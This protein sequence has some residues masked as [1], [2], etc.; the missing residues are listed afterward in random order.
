MIYCGLLERQIAK[1]VGHVVDVSSFFHYFSFDVMGELSFGRS[2]DMLRS[3]ERH[4]AI[5]LMKDGMTLLGLFT[6]TPW[7][8][9]IGFS[10]PGVA[11]GWKKMFVWS[12]EQMRQRIARR[13]ERTDIT[14]WLI[15]ASKRNN[16]LEVDR[17][18]LNGDAFGIIIAGSD[19]TASTL[20]LVFYHLAREPQHFRKIRDELDALGANM[21]ARNLQTLP[22]LNAF[23]NES[24]RLH[25]PVP[26]AGLRET[27]PEGLMIGDQYIPGNTVIGLPMYSLH[28]RKWNLDVKIVDHCDNTGAS[29]RLQLI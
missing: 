4:F 6:P 10:L 26:S 14:S 1:R 24:M 2:F 12:D 23:I 19:T 20:V 11:A 27:P 13:A 8:A 16:S 22:H 15:D 25:P 18:W 17:N 21:D 9:R 29:T 28:R 3:G 7:L 5:D